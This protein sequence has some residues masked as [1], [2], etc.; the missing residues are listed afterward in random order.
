M[1]QMGPR[2]QVQ[3]I[4]GGL[5]KNFFPLMLNMEHHECK[6]SMRCWNGRQ[7]KLSWIEVRI[8]GHLSSASENIF[9]STYYLYTEISVPRIWNMKLAKSSVIY[10]VSFQRFLCNNSRLNICK[11]IILVPHL[12]QNFAD[13]F[14][15]DSKFLQVAHARNIII[16]KLNRC[17]YTMD[18][19]YQ[20]MINYYILDLTRATTDL[21]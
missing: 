9:T 14:T 13:D 12:T 2:A 16:F 1:C 3:D 8:S 17:N 15:P 21:T 18:Y 11:L 6:S 5:T 7:W 20:I 10:A 4:Y 19:C